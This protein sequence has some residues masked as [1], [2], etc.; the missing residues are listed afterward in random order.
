MNVCETGKTGFLAPE[1]RVDCIQSL[2]M[3]EAFLHCYLRVLVIIS[4][5]LTELHVLVTGAHVSREDGSPADCV[6]D[7]RLASMFR[8]GQAVLQRAPATPIVYGTAVPNKNLEI[9][10]AGHRQ[11]VT[12]DASGAWTVKLRA[13]PAG[14]N[15]PLTVK[16]AA[17]SSSCFVATSVSFGETILCAGQSNMGM[18]VV[19]TSAC[20]SQPAPRPHTCH[21]FQAQNGTAEVAAAGR[22]TGKIVIASVGEASGPH[23]GTYCPYP[24]TNRS[25]VSQ[26]EWNAVLP[27]HTGTIAKFSAICWYT[28][29]ALFEALGE[30][31]PI[32]LIAGAV[33]GS[34]IEF[35][36]PPGHVN[37]TAHCGLDAPPCDNNQKY[38]DSDFW[39][40]LIKPFAP[41]TI[42]TAVWD[43]GERDVHCLP[44]PDHSTVP[45]NHVARY[46]CMLREL[47]SS[48][49]AAFDAAHD[50]GFLAVQ[51]PGYLGDCGTFDECRASVFPMRLQQ[52]T[53]LIG[54]DSNA[55]MAS[56]TPTYDLS[57]PPGVDFSTKTA[58]CPFGTVH[59]V[60]KRPIGARIAA[61][62]IAGIDRRPHGAEQGGASRQQ[63]PGPALTSVTASGA[64][65][66]TVTVNVT[67][68]VPL[69]QAPT[70]NCVACCTKGTVG[71]FDVSFDHGATWVNGTR[72]TIGVDGRTL[73]FTVTPARN[74]T[75]VR[76]QVTHVR[77][78]ANQP[79]PQC[80]IYAAV[81]S[82]HHEQGGNGIPAMPFEVALTHQGV[83]LATN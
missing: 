7:I 33:G 40:Q 69:I 80:A 63:W 76:V 45:E 36:L 53:G 35:W 72:P 44:Q 56:T 48:W 15:V 67:Y 16:P 77:Y 58:I 18:P 42:G 27:G 39:D 78:T 68:A 62:I 46:G 5:C 1:I 32:G 70:L 55:A 19:A 23:N 57:C 24:W 11:H 10:V 38:R 50:F 47:V 22:Y 12:A 20:C 17:G 9:T 65:D 51:L 73:Q 21:C 4:L 31:V 60:F 13:H 6:H 59:N 75:M 66:N 81:A 52:Q 43:Q 61:Q 82:E 64:V 8:S 28:G 79:F 2:A 74:A 3:A 14:W 30:T 25:C 41:Y 49:R 83:W 29:I 26:P 54:L 71:D 37:D 34:P